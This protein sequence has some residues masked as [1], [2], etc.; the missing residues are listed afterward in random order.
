MEIQGKLGLKKEDRLSRI[1]YISPI[2]HTKWLKMFK[3]G[4]NDEQYLSCSACVAPNLLIKR[5]Q[6]WLAVKEKTK[7]RIE[8]IPETL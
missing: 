1:D 6:N 8:K 2:L 4:I 3:I 5:R 7:T